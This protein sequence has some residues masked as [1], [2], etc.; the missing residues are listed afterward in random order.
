M[1]DLDGEQH[2]LGCQVPGRWDRSATQNQE[3]TQKKGKWK[4]GLLF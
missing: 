1:N 4:A 3:K 2:I